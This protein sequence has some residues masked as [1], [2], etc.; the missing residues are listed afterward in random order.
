[1]FETP[2]QPVIQ[3]IGLSPYVCGFIT[4]MNITRW[5]YPYISPERIHQAAADPMA[6]LRRVPWMAPRWPQLIRALGTGP[7]AQDAVAGGG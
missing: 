1:M 7:G 6:A 4:P 2:F 3:R 5:S